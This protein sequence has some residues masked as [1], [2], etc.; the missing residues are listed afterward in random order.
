MTTPKDIYDT[1]IVYR[2]PSGKLTYFSKVLAGTLEECD[3]EIRRVLSNEQR[4]GYAVP[5]R[6]DVQHVHGRNRRMIRA[7][8]A[9]V[10]MV[11]LV[12]M[13]TDNRQALDACQQT[14]SFDTCAYA[15]R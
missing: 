9:I 2:T 10:A 1:E 5:R 12:V 4:Y 11:A 6:H 13:A 8:L 15:L 3:A 7:T 14:H